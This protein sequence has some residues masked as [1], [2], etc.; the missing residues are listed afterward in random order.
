MR[1][2]TRPGTLVLAVA[3]AAGTV[4]AQDAGQQQQQQ[5]SPE[6]QAAMEAWQKSMTPGPAHKDFADLVGK[7]KMTSRS[8]MAPGAPPDVS[9][10]TTEFTLILGGRFVRQDAKATMMGLPFDGIGLTGYDNTAKQYQAIWIDSMGTGMTYFTGQA[11]ASG[12]VV[13]YHGTMFDPATGK[14]TK[15]RS[16][17][18]ILSKDRSMFEMYT[19]LPD[20]TEF[21]MME[22][23]YERQ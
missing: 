16:V 13:T 15:L 20:G 14:P 11:D 7:W 8:W 6:Q 12:K 19:P 21:K 5:M 22:I 4:L 9:I 3:L 10:G 1:S 17:A 18:T 23:V 2:T